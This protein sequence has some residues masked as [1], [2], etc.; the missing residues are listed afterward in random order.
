V[1]MV[2]DGT[3]M[4]MMNET[5]GNNGIDWDGLG[6]PPE[7]QQYIHVYTTPTAQ[8]NKKARNKN[9]CEVEDVALV[10]VWLDTSIDAIPGI[11]KKRGGFWTRIHNFYHSKKE[12][13]V[14]RSPNSL[15]HRWTT[16]QECVNKFCG[17][18]TAIDGSNQSGK[19]FENKVCGIEV[20]CIF[21]CL[22]CNSKY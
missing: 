21:H 20:C 18:F 3:Y 7:E 5:L 22:L 16:I 8:A 12:I 4:G 10:R 1:R 17:C 15:S 19:T 6:S 9:F 11:N 2:T 14:L 13:T